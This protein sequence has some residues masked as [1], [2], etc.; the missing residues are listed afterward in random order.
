MARL[1]MDADQVEK[2][3]RELRALGE[4]VGAIA[5]SVD[6]LIAGIGAVWFGASGQRLQ[7]DWRSTH[8]PHVVQGAESLRS[9]ARTALA[10]AAD[11]RRTSATLDGAPSWPGASAVPAGPTPMG[12]GVPAAPPPIGSQTPAQNAAWWAG[13]SEDQRAWVIANHPDWIGNRDGIDFTSRD[14]ANRSLLDGYLKDSVAA[15]DA[16]VRERNELLARQAGNKSGWDRFTDSL[17]TGDEIVDSV[18]LAL[19]GKEIQYAQERVE[20]NQKVQEVLRQSVD[21]HLVLFDPSGLKTKAAVAIGD[22]D[23]ADHI[24]VFTPGISTRVDSSLQGYVGDVSGLKSETEAVLRLNG[25]GDE[26]VAT[27]AWL[28]YEAPDNPMER[29]DDL[30]IPGRSTLFDNAAERGA[31]SLNSFYA[32]LSSSRADDPHLVALGHSYGSLT[33]SLGLQAGG[34]GVDDAVFFGSPGLD[35]KDPG[36]L[37]VTGSAYLLE[38]RND[39]VA[40]LGAFGGDA[41]QVPGVIHLSTSEASTAAGHLKESTGHSEYLSPNTT[42]QRN[43]ANVLASTPQ[44]AVWGSN[45]GFGDALRQASEHPIVLNPLA[46]GGSW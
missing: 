37:H 32:G 41:S 44:D 12:G 31:V 27:V 24:G 6:G 33:T 19:L 30:L 5:G 17:F 34:T 23:H 7:S 26:S 29:Q 42:S 25:R 22:L 35:I 15:R 46:T 11:Q 3:G 28:G 8:R 38:A 4:Q 21:S 13:L 43:M 2:V 40:D 39:A 18:K 10:N 20:S 45:S 14:A 9:L 36:E 16:L 1:G